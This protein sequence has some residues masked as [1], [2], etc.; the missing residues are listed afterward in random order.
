MKKYRIRHIPKGLH[1][2][3]LKLKYLLLLLIMFLAYSTYQFLYMK[4]CPVM[5]LAHIKTI[6]FWGILSLSVIFIVGFFIERFWCKYL[7]PYAA[8]MNVLLFVGN[9]LHIPRK[10]IAINQE[11]CIN[12]N[13]CEKVCPMQIDL[14]NKK[15][16][17]NVECILCK[18]CIRVCKSNPKAIETK[19]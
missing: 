17:K 3:L 12:C 9:L 15:Y 13:K 16:I 10:K 14:V 7:C 11:F 4:F 1:R 19:Y 5:A 18:K 2:V 8:L 6:T